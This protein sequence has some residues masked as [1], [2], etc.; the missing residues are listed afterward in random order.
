MFN[1]EIILNL[2][3][4]SS[5]LNIQITENSL[6]KNTELNLIQETWIIF[7]ISLICICIWILSITFLNLII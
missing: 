5:L 6:F 2:I 7:F 3:F 1:K 4:V